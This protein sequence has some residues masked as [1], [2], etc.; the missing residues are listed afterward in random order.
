MQAAQGHGENMVETMATTSV[1]HKTLFC[2][3]YSSMKA[4]RGFNGAG[5]R[6]QEE[7]I[8]DIHRIFA[9]GNPGG[10]PK[11]PEIAK[12]LREHAP[13]DADMPDEGMKAMIEKS[14]PMKQKNPGMVISP[15]PQLVSTTMEEPDRE[16]DMPY[17]SRKAN[18]EKS[19]PDEE[20]HI[21]GSPHWKDDHFQESVGFPMGDGYVLPPPPAK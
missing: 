14:N 13:G 21:D 12:V 10:A 2:G 16:V 17:E 19:K 4:I 8:N 6:T 1:S 20:E 11:E 7:N 15:F 3:A 18:N 9:A 5:T